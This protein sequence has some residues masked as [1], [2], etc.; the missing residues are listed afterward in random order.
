MDRSITSPEIFFDKA[1]KWQAEM[2]KLREIVLT[3]GLNE[4]VKWYQPCYTFDGHNIVIIGAFKDYCGLGFFNGALLK[5]PQGVLTRTGDVQ[6]GR[7]MCFTSLN[8]VEEMA[9]VIKAY[10]AEAI[11]VEKAGL[12][13]EPRKTEDYPVSVEFQEKLDAD[14]ALKAAFEALTP[15]RQRGYLYFLAAPKQSA[16]RTARIEKNLQRIL[17]GK[18][19]ND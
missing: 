11:E 15:G 17:D 2:R 14:P 6:A 4:E 3:C 1:Q 18:G 19:L 12:K 16:T 7:M 13:V 9:P 5:D 10:I 8:E